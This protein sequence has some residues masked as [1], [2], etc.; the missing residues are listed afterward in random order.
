MRTHDLLLRVELPAVGES[1]LTPHGRL[2]IDSIDN[3]R[4]EY[5][6]ERGPI[7]IEHVFEYEPDRSSMDS[8]EAW[9]ACPWQVIYSTN[10]PC[11][12]SCGQCDYR[13]L[14]RGESRKVFHEKRS[15][16]CTCGTKHECCGYSLPTK[17]Q[18]IAV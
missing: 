3:L 10:V 4:D 18:A 13:I 6:T 9:L 11:S 5:I 16:A 15:D 2:R 12:C 1:I 17:I 8:V 14:V 7:A